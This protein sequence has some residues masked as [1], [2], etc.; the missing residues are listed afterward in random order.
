MNIKLND[1]IS[2]VKLNLSLYFDI[3]ETLFFKV[4]NKMIEQD[5]VSRDTDDN[6]EKLI[7]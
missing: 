7:Y 1:L 3:N 4:L 6:I 5:Y 2:K